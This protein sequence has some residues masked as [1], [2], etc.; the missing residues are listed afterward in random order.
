VPQFDRWSLSQIDGGDVPGIPSGLVSRLA[1][2][3]G[4]ALVAGRDGA[5]VVVVNRDGRA[6]L[7]EEPGDMI[8]YTPE[9]CD[10]L[11]LSGQPMAL[12]NRGWLE[13]S[14]HGAYPD[15]PTQLIQLFRSTR[16]G[17][18]VVAAG[19]GAD[20]RR[21]WEIPLHRSGQGSL[22]AAHMRCLLV[23]NRPVAG[24]M[25]TVDVFPLVLHHLGHDIPAGIDGRR[26]SLAEWEAA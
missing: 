11:E 8:R 7:S 9:T 24:V 13:H 3:E 1:Q 6:R 17:D 25:R 20:L 4:V 5:D 2:L 18:L 22:T 26:P 14:Y 16:S 23:A 10:V 19:P 21:D 12:D 15:G